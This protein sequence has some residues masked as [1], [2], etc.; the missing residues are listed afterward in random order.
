LADSRINKK[1][2]TNKEIQKIIEIKFAKTGKYSVSASSLQ[3]YFNCSLKWLFERVLKLENIQIETSLMAEDLSGLVYHAVLNDFF[4]KLKNSVLL[5]PLFSN[6]GLSLPEPYRGHLETSINNI[7]NAFPLLNSS[8]HPQMSALTAR[9][10]NSVKKEF[11]YNLEKCLSHF[12][13]LFAGCS[14][15]RSEIDYQA[16][17]NSYI[18]NGIID[19]VLKDNSLDSDNYIIVDFKLKNLPNRGDCTAENNNSLADFQLPMYITL[20]EKNEDFEVS[21]ALF[22]SILDLKPQVIIG[23]VRDELNNKNFP[24]Y[25]EDQITCGSELYAKLFDEFEYKTSQ[26]AQEISTG[27][28]T[29]FPENSNDCFTCDFQRICRTVYIIDRENDLSG[30]YK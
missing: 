30:K 25:K 29:V 1:W 2:I 9:L 22:Y 14:V 26:F 4:I 13:S 20:A 10:L 24:K 6:Y 12:L 15:I 28:F 19:C 7:F 17:Q 23:T 5:K 8:G 11:H 18:M 16:D 21:T 3:K 27:N